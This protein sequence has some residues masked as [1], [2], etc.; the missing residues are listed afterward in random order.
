MVVVMAT[1]GAQ[2]PAVAKVAKPIATM[3]WV[4]GGT[5][6]ADASNLGGGMQR[7]ETRYDWSDNGSFIRFNTHFVTDKGTLKNYDG[8]FFYDPS[9][10]TLSM[11]Y[12]DASG[13]IT[14]GPM[15]IEGD[16]WQMSFHGPDFEGKMADLQVNVLRK[17]NDLY[18][19]SV[20]ERVGQE[21]K[22]LLEL[23]Y[24]RKP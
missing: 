3:A 6:I 11:W 4:I 15:A 19:W 23:D 7:I 2:Q 8:N 9:G 21:W 17:S 20:S 24:A 14:Q 13:E 1:A 22:K 10:K 16:V 5:W 18:H 12:M